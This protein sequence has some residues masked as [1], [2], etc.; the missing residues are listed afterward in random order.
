MIK[1]PLKN[2]GKYDETYGDLRALR[3]EVRSMKDWCRITF[4]KNNSSSHKW[5]GTL[6]DEHHEIHNENGWEVEYVTYY[7][8]V[9]YFSD[10]SH[11]TLFSLRWA[12]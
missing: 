9:F 2:C 11:A 1:V 12:K 10:K 8:P 6:T 3:L 7:Y 4:G 5:R